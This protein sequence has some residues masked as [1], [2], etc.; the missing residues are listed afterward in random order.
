MMS[1]YITLSPINHIITEV[2]N[3]SDYLKNEFDDKDLDF[4]FQKLVNYVS[5]VLK[6]EEI[7]CLKTQVLKSKNFAKNI[8]ILSNEMAFTRRFLG[9]TK[10]GDFM[11]FFAAPTILRFYLIIDD[12]K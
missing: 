6:C 4:V 11:Y 10:R 9:T 2:D 5:I 8:T 12:E 1:S 3:T 7:V